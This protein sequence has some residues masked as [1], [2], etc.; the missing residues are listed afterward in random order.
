MKK[1]LKSLIIFICPICLVIIVSEALLRKIPND[2]SYKSSYLDTNSNDIEVLFLGSSHFFFGVNPDYLSYR[3]FNAANVSQ[4]L[5]LDLEILSKY[6]NEWRNL[7]YIVVPVDYYSLFSTLTS[8]VESWREKNYSLY[9]GIKTHNDVFEANEFFE[10]KPKV[11]L[12]RLYKYYLKGLSG[13]TCSKL[14]WGEN[15]QSRVQK[16]LLLTGKKAALR[17]RAKSLQSLDYTVSIL[18]EM[19]AFAKAKKLKLIFITS[20][21]FKSYRQ[22]LDTTQLAMVA[23][24]MRRFV[25]SDPNIFYYNWLSDE[26]YTKS[27]FYD[28][29]HLN[30]IGA[31]KLSIKIDSVLKQINHRSDITYKQNVGKSQAT[32]Q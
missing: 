25:I 27:D 30:E 19:I 7:Q 23:K 29:D 8:S 20:P 6:K 13:I 3:S 12:G 24:T 10:N 17:H 15:Y 16:N 31:R 4:S 5:D 18:Q 26:S 1:F 11:N 22:N 14:G 21:A 28:A 9:F 2:Y 32:D